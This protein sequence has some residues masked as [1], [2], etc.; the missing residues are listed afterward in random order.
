MQTAQ[1][2]SALLNEARKTLVGQEEPLTLLLTALLSGGHVLLEGPPGTAKTLMAKTLAQMI[3]ADFR[4]IQFTPDLM[5]SDIVGTQ[6]FDLSSSQF[7]LR[8]G[9]IFTQ[10]LLGDEINRA[11]AKTQSALLEAMEERQVTIEGQ[12]LPLPEPFFVI[13][14]Q[15]PIEFEGTYPLPE[16]QLDRFLFKV[17]IDYASREVETEVLRRYHLGF[18]AHQLAAAGLCP[19]VTPEALAACRAEIGRVQVEQGILDYIVSIVQ[20]TRTSP[21]LL[22]GASLRAGVAMLLAAKTL[23]AIHDRSYVTPDEVKMLARPVLRHR[24]ILRPEA[25]IEGLNAD[26]AIGRILNRVEVPR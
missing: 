15:N 26:M 12:R 22:V 16:A 7:R 18:D 14:T 9:P 11:P 23:A 4:R 1:L 24:I 5:P 2:A 25:E 10:V 21:E 19:I 17:V 20:A 13:A 6:V 8:Q 3:Q